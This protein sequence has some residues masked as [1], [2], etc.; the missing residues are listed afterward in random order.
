MS[1]ATPSPPGLK[2]RPSPATE[3]PPK[4]K[5]A[6]FAE[7]IEDADDVPATQPISP[8]GTSRFCE[9]CVEYGECEPCMI[10]RGSTTRLMPEQ[11]IG[12]F[13][14]PAFDLD[15]EE[16]GFPFDF[17][18]VPHPEKLKLY[19]LP[20]LTPLPDASVRAV[21]MGVFPGVHYKTGAAQ[22]WVILITD[23]VE[24]ET[25]LT[26]AYKLYDKTKADEFVPANKAPSKKYRDVS[27][28]AA[29]PSAGGGR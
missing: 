24:A 6:K 10:K 13:A 16:R 12:Y 23:V 28:N 26:I 20:Y 9:C 11:T 25:G 14:F 5:R 7:E 17:S 1:R 15:G 22:D 18:Y 2:K 4:P 3:P 8:P 27:K 19:S 21:G 29:A